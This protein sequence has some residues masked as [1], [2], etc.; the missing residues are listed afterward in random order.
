M[1]KLN[2]VESLPTVERFDWK[3]NVEIIVEVLVNGLSSL[4]DRV[5]LD[6]SLLHRHCDVR[7]CQQDSYTDEQHKLHT[8]RQTD[9]DTHTTGMQTI[10]IA[11]IKPI[12]QVCIH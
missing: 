11:E 10:A 4:D 12:A 1:S 7:A 2:K 9:T 3:I 6:Q 5:L 8:D